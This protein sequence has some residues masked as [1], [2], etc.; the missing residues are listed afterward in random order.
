MAND[1]NPIHT[2]QISQR[3]VLDQIQNTYLTSLEDLLVSVDSELRMPLR[4]KWQS[5]TQISIE[6]SEI[7]NPETSQKRTL[8]LSEG[9]FLSFPVGTIFLNTGTS[10]F[11]VTP[12][13]DLTLTTPEDFVPIIV[14][15]DTDSNVVLTRCEG[16]SSW[17]PS[18]LT[19]ADFPLPVNHWIT[20]MILFQTPHTEVLP[21]H[22]YQFTPWFNSGSQKTE[23]GQV[24]TTNYTA[25]QSDSVIR[26]D[27]SSG[28]V[29]V[30]LGSPA[31]AGRV[32][33]ICDVGGVA[34]ETGHELTVK[35]TGFVVREEESYEF[36]NDYESVTVVS[37][38]AGRWEII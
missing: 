18:L 8:P 4:L 6:A 21:E 29:T 24:V 17:P 37:N 11:E 23:I 16:F 27:T 13:P 9:R 38:G 20:G 15:V 30:E 32:L 14:S 28:P 34:S 36:F 31:V 7:Q 5:N 2:R 22:I 35:S 25:V 1:P 26:V 3:D 12:G 19:L 33:T 10:T